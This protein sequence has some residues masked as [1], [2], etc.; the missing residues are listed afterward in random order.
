MIKQPN[1]TREALAHALALAITAPTDE[2]SAAALQ[3]A[4][5]FAAN[6]NA[7]QVESAQRYSLVLVERA[8][9]DAK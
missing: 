7:L 2:K 4:D 9:R 6:L 8:M 5:T 1:S 3:L